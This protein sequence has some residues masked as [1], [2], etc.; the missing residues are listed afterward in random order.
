M[1]YKEFQKQLSE[2]RSEENVKYTYAKYFNI[3]F[4]ASDRVDLYTPNVLFEFKLNKNISNLKSRATILAQTL[5]YIR[6][7]KF[8]VEDKII[9]Y[10]ICLADSK[11]AC[12][13]ETN[14]WKTYY[15]N[16]T[17][18]WKRAASKPDP[19][20]ID[21]LVKENETS[22]IMVYKITDSTEYKEFKKKLKLALEPQIRIDLADKKV[23]TES[24]FEAVYGHWN[25]DIG[26]H[27]INGYKHSLYF[28][29]NLQEDKIAIDRANNKV[30]FTL[31]DNVVKS[32]K[33]LM[34]DYDSFWNMYS[35]IENNDVINGIHIKLDRLTDESQRRFEGEFY[36]PLKFCQKAIDYWNE[37]LGRE[38]YKTGKYRIWDMAAGTGNLLYYLP[39][40]AYKYLYL[41]TLHESDVE[42]LSRVFKDATCFQYDYLNDDVDRLFSNDKS[43]FENEWKMP[44]Q[45]LN[46]LGNP[47]LTWIVF[48]NP[49]FATAQD[50]KQKKSKTKVSDTRVS[51]YMG[52]EKLSHTKRELFIQFIF[53]IINEIP[54]RA[55]LGM[56]STLKYLNAPDSIDFREKYFS[57]KY[58]KGFLF[59]SKCFNK[60]EGDFPVSFLIWNLSKQRVKNTVEID[61]SNENAENIGVKHL[62][63]INKNEVL[64]KWFERPQNSKQHILPPLSNG[65]TIKE[66]N[67]D[68]RHRARPDFLAS[69]CSKGNDFQNIRYV[70]ILSS[71]NVS[72]GAF[73]VIPDNF[74][75]AVAIYAVRKIS[76]PNWLNDRN[77]F[78]VPSIDP[79]PEFYADCVIW[80]LFSISNET[81]S[82]KDVEYEGV[83][84][85]IIN[86]FYPFLIEEIKEWKISDDVIKR[87]LDEAEDRYVAKWISSKELSKEAITVLSKGREIYKC[88]YKNLNN[89][90]TSEWKISTWDAG[91]YQIRNCLNSHKLCSELIDELNLCSELLSNKIAKKI[92]EYGFLDEDEFYKE[93]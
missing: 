81:T 1:T 57:Y 84:Y 13:T 78:L 53:R 73:S 76:K 26:Q 47:D 39:G 36:T 46:D 23:I 62:K 34:S 40:E 3:T 27:I 16:E 14:K 70:T 64:N 68:K 44:D 32:Q 22:L 88:F 48:I 75:K 58:E 8:Q 86:N 60:V 77:Q 80:S 51:H 11:E 91:W 21:H 50:A 24:N 25:K 52:L 90:Y 72:A 7:L 37:V 66:G 33:I 4:N 83:R 38:W 55:Y 79:S 30:K 54:E 9:P 65:I 59:H 15:M 85:Q 19:L 67:K 31:I 5:Y 35:Y 93:S 56:F 49:P 12:L 69:I 2:A 17:Y 29:S 89:M 43:L 87:Q 10:Y 41:S 45:L 18:D 42:H 74:E 63:L 61:I 28:L 82:L 6:K 20:L 71:P 92:Y